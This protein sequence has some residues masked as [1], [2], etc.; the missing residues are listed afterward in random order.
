MATR[1]L[2]IHL[3]APKVRKNPGTLFGGISLFFGQLV[4]LEWGVAASGGW[5]VAWPIPLGVLYGVYAI[6]LGVKELMRLA[7]TWNAP[8][9]SVR[10][11]PGR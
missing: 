3:A 11:T 6:S 5:K 1:D 4:F 9:R 8:L 2:N 7:W 10:R